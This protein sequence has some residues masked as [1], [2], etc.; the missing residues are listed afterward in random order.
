MSLSIRASYGRWRFET[1]VALHDHASKRMRCMYLHLYWTIDVYVVGLHSFSFMLIPLILPFKKCL[2][3]TPG[4][5]GSSGTLEY[6]A[7]L[8]KAT[9]SHEVQK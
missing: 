4:P 8:G 6:S 7:V 3:S 5:S 2:L 9:R 1:K